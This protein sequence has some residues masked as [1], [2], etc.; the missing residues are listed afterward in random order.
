[1]DEL[2]LDQHGS[3]TDDDEC[4]F[5]REYTS[6]RGYQASA[7]NQLILNLK[8]PVEKRGQRDYRYK[9][10][11]IELAGR[12]LQ[13]ALQEDWLKTAT[14]VPIPPSA[15]KA[16]PRYCFAGC[17]DYLLLRTCWLA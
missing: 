15:Q 11:A 9:L 14:L 1:V 16:D 7:T 17:S 8:K 10:Q 3:L 12:E 4:Y 6:G 2:I 5:L 13:A